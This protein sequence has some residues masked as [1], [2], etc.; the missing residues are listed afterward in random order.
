M[1]ESASER[2]AKRPRAESYHPTVS[3][4]LSAFS[5]IDAGVRR[6][7]VRG[8]GT[9]E[10][11]ICIMRSQQVGH[12]D[13]TLSGAT[14]REWPLAVILIANPKNSDTVGVRRQ[15][16]LVVATR[17]EA[18]QGESC[19]AKKSAVPTGSGSSSFIAESYALCTTLARSLN[20]THQAGIEEKSGSAF[21]L[22][23]KRVE[24]FP[25][26]GQPLALARRKSSPK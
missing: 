7:L 26:P 12:S 22:I 24:F 19:G 13:L 6:T 15:F 20:V 21:P 23:E 16:D 25:V 8:F 5:G 2:I 17:S 14:G 11:G 10:L 4:L 9:P 18:C 3:S 1:V